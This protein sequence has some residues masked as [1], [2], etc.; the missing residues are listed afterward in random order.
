MSTR[1]ASNAPREHQR[2][3]V[4]LGDTTI[5]FRAG[6][7]IQPRTATNTRSTRSRRWRMAAAGRDQGVDGWLFSVH[8]LRMTT[9]RRSLINVH[10]RSRSLAPAIFSYART[11]ADITTE[12]TTPGFGIRRIAGSMT[13]SLS[14]S[15]RARCRPARHEAAALS[16]VFPSRSSISRAWRRQP[17]LTSPADYERHYAPGIFWMTFLEGRHVLSDLAVV[18]RH[19]RWWRHVTASPRRG[20][21]RLLDRPRRAR[22]EIEG[23]CG[24][25]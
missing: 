2:Q 12:D 10:P 21:L 24:D 11:A 13:S 3:K 4:R 25:W 9:D 1:A 18:G 19:A 16:G 15:V 22:R 17:L 14:R 23:R 20:H 8:A 7:T 5:E 6:E